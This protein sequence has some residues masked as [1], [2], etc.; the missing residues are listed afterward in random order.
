MLKTPILNQVRI[1]E[2]NKT[3]KQF[4]QCFFI[5]GNNQEVSE[6]W[7]RAKIIRP[8][9]DIWILTLDPGNI[10][11]EAFEL[12]YNINFRLKTRLNQIIRNFIWDILQQNQTKWTL[13]ILNANILK[14]V[15]IYYH[16]LFFY[17]QLSSINFSCHVIL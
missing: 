13:K 3:F 9:F 4:S 5:N 17:N 12:I 6:Y 1:D 11:E 10:N 7:K 16:I 14:Y 2:F 8:N 15:F